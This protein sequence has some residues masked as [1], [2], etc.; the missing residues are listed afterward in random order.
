MGTFHSPDEG[1]NHTL[2]SFKRCAVGAR[3]QPSGLTHEKMSTAYP[4]PYPELNAVLRE[5]VDS[6]QAVLSHNFVAACL[7]GS[8]AVGDFDRHSDVDFIIAVEEELSDDQVHALQIM[9]ERIYHLDCAWA[10]HLEGSYFLRDVLK[11][12]SR[13][14]E[15]LWYLDNGSRSLVRSDH[16]N[17][18]VVRW[19]V[20]AHGVAL[21]GPDPAT[22]VAPIP[23]ETLRRE[24]MGT[25]SGWGGQILAEPEHYNNRFYQTFIVLS[26]CRMLH[27]LHTGFVGSKRTGAEWAKAILDPSWGGLIDRAWD[28][29]PNPSLSVRRPADP[30][31]FKSTL[32]F[33]Q[34]IIKAS[35]Q[36]AAALETGGQQPR[37]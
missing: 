10:Q 30:K 31:D 29:R 36:S 33:V 4:T 9:H 34:Y 23:V 35:T 20:R 37:A 24:I 15:Q 19:V 32:E 3:R 12:H 8:F 28:G 21:A 27:D 16:C 11:D 25:I 5:L 14:G 18:V 1:S 22:L 7:Q 6:V 26:Y 2:L 13:R 17:T